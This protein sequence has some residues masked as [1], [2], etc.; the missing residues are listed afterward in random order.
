[1]ILADSSVW[2]DH[3]RKSNARL[4][5]LLA[6]G[7]IRTHSHIVGELALGS[8]RDR[9]AF[10]DALVRLPFAVQA[11]EGE[12]LSLIE[13][14]Q[15]YARGIGYTDTHLITSALLTPGTTLWTLDRRLSEAAQ[16]LKIA[17]SH[18]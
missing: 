10:L 12:V 13:Q 6:A 7:R 3:L 18:P 14:K 16:E 4:A 11:S 8:I 5:D 17:A 1:L 2:I 15:L 9:T